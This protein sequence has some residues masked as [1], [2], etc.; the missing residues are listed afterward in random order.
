MSKI[1][2]GTVFTDPDRKQGYRIVE[3]VVSGDVCKSSHFEPLNGAPY[4]V[5]GEELPSWLRTQLEE[6]GMPVRSG[7]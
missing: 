5:P 7:F 6:I 1:D 3:T 2:A 4:P